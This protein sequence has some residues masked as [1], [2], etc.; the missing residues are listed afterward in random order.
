MAVSIRSARNLHRL[1][2]HNNDSQEDDIHKRG[3][4][5]NMNRAMKK[6]LLACDVEYKVKTI[7]RGGNQILNSLLR[8]MSSI[9]HRW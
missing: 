6:K 5:L 8:C 4:T 1:A 3:Y 9:E 7:N 2:A